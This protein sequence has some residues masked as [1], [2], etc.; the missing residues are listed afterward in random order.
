MIILLLNLCVVIKVTSKAVG[1]SMQLSSTSHDIANSAGI[2]IGNKP[3]TVRCRTGDYEG[4]VIY[5]HVNSECTNSTKQSTNWSQIAAS[6][7][8][9]NPIQNSSNSS[10][11]FTLDSPGI[12]FLIATI[13]LKF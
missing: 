13:T 11:S 1:F 3:I 12:T 6:N 9:T 2:I 5:I 10:G 8:S 4:E 7:C